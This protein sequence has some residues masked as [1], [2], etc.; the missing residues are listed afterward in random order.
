MKNILV[1][2]S[3]GSIGKAVLD[4]VDFD[5]DK[6]SILGISGNSNYKELAKQANL[7]KVPYVC[8]SN[9]QHLYEFKK[10]LNY[11]PSIFYDREGL[12]EFSSIKADLAINA[13]VGFEGLLP[14]INAIK[15]GS[16]LGLAN[17]ESLV[18]AG[19]IINK[20]IQEKG[21]KL[22]PVDSEHNAIF[23]C[24]E[25]QSNRAINK[26]YI[27]ASGGPFLNLSL[28]AFSNITPA[29][30]LAH[31]TWSM[32]KKIS[33]DSATMANKVLEVIEARYLFNLNIKDINILIH[34]QSIVHGMVEFK[35]ASL[36]ALLAP[37]SMEL[38]IRYCL[39][40]PEHIV[41]EKNAFIDFNIV[42]KLEFI[43]PDLTRYRVLSLLGTISEDLEFYSVIFNAANEVAV[44]SFLENKLSFNDI[45]A[46]IN[47]SFNLINKSKINEIG[48]IID[49]DMEVRLKVSNIINKRSYI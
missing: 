15:A 47:K 22:I 36:L 8:L 48:H 9:S 33:I 26:I 6:F 27:T 16:N 42:N 3:T 2:G 4:V 17:K 49:L 39:Y 23:Q 30:A 5:R 19:F 12:L 43:N 20:L 44:N 14:C 37:T 18:V 10:L 41:K 31:P 32:G 28:D 45:F 7:L 46:V 29:M 38:P 40:Y 34:P 35:D 24:I 11:S 13:L 25:G 21:L 1:L